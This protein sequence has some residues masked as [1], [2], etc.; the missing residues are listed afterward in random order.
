M[1]G[2]SQLSCTSLR[3]ATPRSWQQ[4]L[5]EQLILALHPLPALLFHQLHCML[6]GDTAVLRKPS[7]PCLLTLS[8][9]PL[10]VLSIG[11]RHSG[12]QPEHPRQ[13]VL[14]C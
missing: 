5:P 3:T 12:L 10:P 11:F 7:H 13:L 14:H 4:L 6:V 1:D 2:L 9:L 8:H